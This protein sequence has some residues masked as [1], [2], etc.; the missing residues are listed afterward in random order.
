[1]ITFPVLCVPETPRAAG[2]LTS[3]PVFYRRHS[4]S[5]EDATGGTMRRAKGKSLSFLTAPAPQNLC[6][7]R[8]LK[9]LPEEEFLKSNS[10]MQHSKSHAVCHLMSRENCEK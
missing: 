8:A 5:P 4:C 1:M 2:Q 7:T 10:L 9:V 3:P 6:Y